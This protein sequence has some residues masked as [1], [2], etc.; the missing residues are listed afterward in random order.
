MG[1][2]S[3]KD[4]YVALT[5]GFILLL[6]FQAAASQFFDGSVQRWV[7]SFLVMTLVSFIWGV[8]GA[9]KWYRSTLGFFAA[10]FLVTLMS[11]ILERFD[12]EIIQLIL[13]LTFFISS[14][15]TVIKQVLFS[16]TVDGNKIFGSICLYILLALIWAVIYSL[17]HISFDGAFTSVADKHW[18]QSFN[19]FVYF[20]FVTM[21][22]LGY[23]DIS[24][25]LPLTEFFVYLE[26]LAGQ[27][28]IAILVASMVGTRMSQKQV[29]ED[30]GETSE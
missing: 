30:Q 22:T 15:A 29:L 7:Q 19:T 10:V 21:T 25:A 26:A 12:L 27:F 8:K 1:Q 24:P 3:E 28:Y 2:I 18:Y 5:I 16:G 17:C 20:S 23:G 13:L 11:A 14:A 4:N 6:L 9:K